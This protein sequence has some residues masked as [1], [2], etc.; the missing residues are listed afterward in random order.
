MHHQ[1]DHISSYWILP[2]WWVVNSFFVKQQSCCRVVMICH[3][4]EIDNVQKHLT[5][6][7]FKKARISS[8]SFRS[9]WILEIRR[10]LRTQPPPKKN[11]LSRPYGWILF[12]L[13]SDLTPGQ[14]LIASFPQLL[15]IEPRKSCLRWGEKTWHFGWNHFGTCSDLFLIFSG[16]PGWWIMI[17][18]IICLEIH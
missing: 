8:I 11:T 4:L 14:A 5:F 3:P 15:V 12:L 2:F 17:I 6:S 16:L 1:S 13:S 10:F 7:V 18:W 9:R